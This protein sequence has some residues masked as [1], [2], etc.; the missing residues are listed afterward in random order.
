MSDFFTRLAARTLGLAP[1]LQPIIAPI[2]AQEQA[3]QQADTGPFEFFLEEETPDHN[4]NTTQHDGH[5]QQQR[6]VSQI[7]PVSSRGDSQDDRQG[8]FIIPQMRLPYIVNDHQTSIQMQKS[9]IPERK[10]FQDGRDSHSHI[11]TTDQ[12]SV[13]M[14]MSST[15]DLYQQHPAS[16]TTRETQIVHEDIT[17]NSNI[18]NQKEA[19]NI[20]NAGQ[21]RSPEI[22]SVRPLPPIERNI[23]VPLTPENVRSTLAVDLPTVVLAPI[24]TVGQ[25]SI[26]PSPKHGGQPFAADLLA[27]GHVLVD[28]PPIQPPPSVQITIGR[29]EVRATSSPSPSVTARSAPAPVVKSLDDYVRQREEGR[30]R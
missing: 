12:Q 21:Q 13:P 19:F 3:L 9:S 11:L 16:I 30:V 29:I 26:S 22:R 6:A 7:L 1:T 17:I 20:D 15:F 14:Q 4:G 24:Q 27:V 10:S 5:A 28:H 8:A 23:P 25:M 18:Q 2:F